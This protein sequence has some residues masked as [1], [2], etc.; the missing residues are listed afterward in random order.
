MR[1]RLFD[2][3]IQTSGAD[4]DDIHS[5]EAEGNFWDENQP[6]ICKLYDFAM[7]K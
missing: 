3:I 1:N 6:T 4:T 7:L 2:S 5:S